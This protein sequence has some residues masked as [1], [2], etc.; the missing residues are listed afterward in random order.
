MIAG[1]TPP[2]PPLCALA[3]DVSSPELLGDN[4]ALFEAAPERAVL[5]PPRE[6]PAVR[7]VE[8]VRPE[9]AATRRDGARVE[10]SARRGAFEDMAT[11]LFAAVS[12]DT[13]HFTTSNT[14]AEALEAAAD[15]VRAGADVDLVTR[16]IYR[17]RTFARTKLLGLALAG[18]EMTGGVAHACVTNPHVLKRPGPCAR[19]PSASSII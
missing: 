2:F 11:C 10:P 16:R 14:T 8:R 1:P 17:T 6:Q 3:V 4:L 15:C 7:P 9:R 13:G 19:T 12:S 18:I 5:D